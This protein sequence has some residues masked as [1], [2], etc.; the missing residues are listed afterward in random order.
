[1]LGKT[2]DSQVCSIA[3]ALELIGE[4]W[5]LLIVRDAVFGGATRY[6]DFQR[7]L[8]VATNILKSRLDGFVEAGLMRR[9]RYSEQPELYEYLLTDKGR[10]LAPALVALSEWGDR[11]ATEGEPPILYTHSVCGTG[12]SQRTVC[13]HCGQVDDAAEIQAVIG[14]GMPAERIKA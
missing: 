4:R 3:R 5:S 9:H 14:P 12:V 6:S 10:A 13:A 2:Y 1:M 7:N 8:G 11:W